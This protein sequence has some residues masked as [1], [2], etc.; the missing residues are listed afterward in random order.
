MYD[1]SRF[2]KNK[3]NSQGYKIGCFDTSALSRLQKWPESSIINIFQQ[4]NIR[5]VTDKYILAEW[6]Q[7]L[8][9]SSKTQTQIDEFISEK[10]AVI[11]ALEKLGLLWFIERHAVL[12]IE[13]LQISG[14]NIAAHDYYKVFADRPIDCPGSENEILDEKM[15]KNRL[16]PE[17]KYR[18]DKGLKYVFRPYK[19]TSKK[20]DWKAYTLEMIDAK[21]ADILK[22]E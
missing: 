5:P 20:I 10:I 11:G 22:K 8:E 16:K 4:Y 13:C 14:N 15:R 18:C 21:L 12:A 19:S 17:D 7:G 6:L 1:Y 9:N 2:T 3:I